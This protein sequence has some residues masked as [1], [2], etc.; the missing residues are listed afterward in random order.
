MV[1]YSASTAR[2]VAASGYSFFRARG[3]L[4]RA[5]PVPSTAA[6]HA[7][8]RLLTTGLPTQAPTLLP[9]LSQGRRTASESVQ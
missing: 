3:D 5:D 7:L 8:S 9:L 6:V 4:P 1:P 2:R